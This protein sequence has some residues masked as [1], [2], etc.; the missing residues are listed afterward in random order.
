MKA[1]RSQLDTYNLQRL[2][3]EK[4]LLLGSIA[5]F[6][7]IPDSRARS[8]AKLI[9]EVQTRLLNVYI[10][11]GEFDAAISLAQE[12]GNAKLF[13]YA[14]NI[15]LAFEVDD[16]AI[17]QCKNDVHFNGRENVT[18]SRFIKSTRVWRYTSWVDVYKCIKCG[19]FNAAN[20]Y[21]GA[22]V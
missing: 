10:T 1:S 14:G 3:N 11:L 20:N 9:E 17:C 13:H 8:R 21:S 12:M 2:L 15:K 18:L 19:F 4:A 6:G 5:S 7:K 22:K 16:H